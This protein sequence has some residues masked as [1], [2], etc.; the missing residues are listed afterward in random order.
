MLHPKIQSG[1]DNLKMD[2]H[3]FCARD[4]II[5]NKCSNN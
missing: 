3:D 1:T 2:L 4:K 5:E